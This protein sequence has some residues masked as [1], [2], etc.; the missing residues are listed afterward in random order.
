MKERCKLHPFY[1]EPC[2]ICSDIKRLEDSLSEHLEQIEQM[3]VLTKEL[4]EEIL[5]KDEVIMSMSKKVETKI[6][7]RIDP[8]YRTRLWIQDLNNIRSLE[9]EILDKDE[10]IMS[11]S[12]RV[13]TKV[14]Q[15]IDPKYRTRL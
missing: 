8:K 15:R 14:A 9:E 13:E 5:D 7:K 2:K 10:V 6:A 3:K 4:E 1:F 11:M 12:K